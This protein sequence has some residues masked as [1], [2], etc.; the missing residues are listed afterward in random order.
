MI[1]TF[2]LLI[3]VLVLTGCG[4]SDEDVLRERAETY[5]GVL[6]AGPSAEEVVPFVVPSAGRELQAEQMAEQWQNPEAEISDFSVDAVDV[7]GNQA[8]VEFTVVATHEGEEVVGTD[9]TLWRKVDGTW[10]RDLD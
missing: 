9:A 3:A 1:R 10:Y 5:A 2:L 6:H 7:D 4:Q 8:V